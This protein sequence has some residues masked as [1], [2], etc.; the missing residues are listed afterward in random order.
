MQAILGRS[1]QAINVISEKKEW[2][3]A[4]VGRVMGM[5]EGWTILHLAVWAGDVSL[6][7]WLLTSGLNPSSPDSRSDTPLTLAAELS[8][9]EI[10]YLLTSDERSQATVIEGQPE[11]GTKGEYGP[12]FT[13]SSIQKREVRRKN[14][15]E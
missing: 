15:E 7:R 9:S 3:G 5:K 12:L 13:G 1:D 6:V 8:D 2:R 4:R 10:L 11:G 14:G